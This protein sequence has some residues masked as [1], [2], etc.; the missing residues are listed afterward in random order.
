[1]LPS[2]DCSR[3]STAAPRHTVSRHNSLLAT[4]AVCAALAVPARAAAQAPAV[5]PPSLQ[6]LEQKMAQIRFN[7]ARVAIRF[8]LG[9]L[10]PAVSGAELGT[11]ATG[12]DSFLTSVTVAVRRSPPESISTSRSEGLKL[13]AGHTL[14]GST[15]TERMIGKAI[16]TYKPSVASYD[17]GR[18]WV[19]SKAKPAPEPGSDSAKLSAVFGSLSPT[20]AGGSSGGSTGLFSKLIEELGEAQS[21]QEVG[22]AT[23]DAQQVTEFTALISLAKLLSPKQLEGITKSNSSLGELLSPIGSPKQHEE[24]KQHNE[25]AA[26]KLSETTVV[27]ELFIA[28]SGLPVRTISV[29]GGRSEG[30]GVEED[31]LA[32]EIPVVVHAPPARETIGEAQLSRLEKKHAKQVCSIIKVGAASNAQPVLCPRSPSKRAL[33]RHQDHTA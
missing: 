11:G 22:P 23:V 9:D 12:L 29:L 28:P 15:S 8:G 33:R 25:E 7:T 6:S 32:L 31:I 16:Y 10:G 20:F 13:S 26:K 18:P 5:I 21:I 4:L 24:A 3:C 14:G 27:L 30:I 19:R 17:G 2:A 1:L